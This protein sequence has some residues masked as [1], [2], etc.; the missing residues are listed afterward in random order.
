MTAPVDWDVVCG[1]ADRLSLRPGERLRLMV[2]SVAETSAEL[3]RLPDR[4]P[5]AGRATRLRDDSPQ[6]VLTGS[7]VEVP[8]DPAL[9]PRDGLAVEVWVW[10]T[11]GAPRGARRALVSSWSP[12]RADG[13]ALVLDSAARPRFELASAGRRVGVAAREPLATG[14]WARVEGSLEPAAGTVSVSVEPAGGTT[15]T[16]TTA[17]ALDGPGPGPGPLL[18]GGERSGAAVGAL[19]DGK[20]SRPA[21][22]CGEGAAQRPVAAWALGAGRD[23]GVADRGPHGLAGRCVNGPLRAV[24]GPSWSGDVHDWR[25]AGDQYDA[26][27]FHADATDDLGWEPSLEFELPPAL[28]GG[29]YAAVLSAAGCEDVVP[30]VVRRPAAGEPAANAVL[31]PTF[32][33]LAYSCERAA[34]AIG[35]SQQAE[36]RW[37]AAAGLRSLY[38]RHADGSGVYEA[39][40]RRPLT[41]LRPGYRCAQ[42]GGPH[43]LAQD[44]IL[45]GFLA[46]RGIDADLLTD[47]DLHAEGA[48]ALTGHRTL[49]TGAHPEY[50]TAELI[51]A[52]EAH[53]EGG[54]NLAYLGGN[55]LNGS[56]SVDPARPH[57][58]ELRRTETQGLVWQALPGEHHHAST[59]A[60]GG[61]WRRRGHPEHRLLGVG[62]CAFGD[63]PATDYERIVAPGDP[64]GDVVFAGL[65]PATAIGHRGAV[66]GGAAGFEIDSHD[67]RLGSPACAVILASADP[68]PRYERWGDDVISDQG[69]THGPPTGPTRRA[70]M[71]VH[72]ERGGVVFSVGSIAWSGCLI[73]DDNPIATVTAN[74]LGELARERPFTALAGE[75]V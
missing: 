31:L 52:L 38:D 61:D 11:A 56:V 62:L 63:A 3:V 73:D 16:A 17:A 35:G 42:H 49:I 21:I 72:R 9:R 58:I 29:V 5:V 23:G 67:P 68:G 27:Y 54:G 48:A 28:A 7:F 22:S 25:F 60:Y 32:T 47:H 14:V 45:L 65:D 50:A 39:S 46:R 36:D 8:H 24:T 1:Y 74:V 43:G 69:H 41:Q 44:L 30:F 75:R 71:V 6:P 34:P 26:M 59:G 64:V 20:L 37:V 15:R 57:V 12:D 19:L 18:L 53:V 70:D 40:I 13:F 2:S 66:L 4:A 55:G 33:Y 10:I 51:E